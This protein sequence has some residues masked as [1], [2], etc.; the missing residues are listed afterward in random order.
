MMVLK[1]PD[2]Q[3]KWSLAT[4][5]VFAVT[6]IVSQVEETLKRLSKDRIVRFLGYR[7]LEI[8]KTNSKS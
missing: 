6:Q 4:Y 8:W 7:T 1:I 5:L 2:K 3:R